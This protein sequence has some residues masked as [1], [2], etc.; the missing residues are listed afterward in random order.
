MEWRDRIHD[1]MDRGGFDV[2]DESD[3]IEWDSCA[4]GEALLSEGVDVDTHLLLSS[5]ATS[6]VEAGER[7]SVL[8]ARKARA[9]G[10]RFTRAVQNNE[11]VKTLGLLNEIEN[12]AGLLAEALEQEGGR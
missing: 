2:Y 1:A 4:V 5:R 8:L 10:L 7:E 9:L 3:A 11:L 12:V 6:K